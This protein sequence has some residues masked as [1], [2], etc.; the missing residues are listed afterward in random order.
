MPDNIYAIVYI[1]SND[2]AINV[3]YLLV[4]SGYAK[5]NDMPN[6]FDTSSWVISE[7]FEA[8]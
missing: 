4:Q 1:I 8:Q 2:K 7:P 5:I 6:E 3:N